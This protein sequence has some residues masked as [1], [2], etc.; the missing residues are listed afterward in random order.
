MPGSGAATLT[1]PANLKW[2]SSPPGLW[3]GSS[4]HS[5]GSL[6][7]PI[8]DW[9][10]LFSDAVPT[11]SAGGECSGVCRNLVLQGSTGKKELEAVVAPTMVLRGH[12][13]FFF[14]IRYFP[15]LHFQ[16]YPKSPQY[17]PPPTHSH[18]LALAFPCTGAYKVCKSNG[19]VSS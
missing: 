12:L 10:S 9:S 19:P 11:H 18:F 6:P 7:K 5:T 17:T 15:H 4:A 8:L 13:F 16:C 2:L 14:L 3:E 1:V